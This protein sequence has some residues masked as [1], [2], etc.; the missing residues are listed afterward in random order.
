MKVLIFNPYSLDNNSLPVLLDEAAEYLKDPSTEVLFITCT[1][2]MKPCDI[3]YE[4]S[5]VRCAECRLSTWLLLNRFRASSFSHRTLADYVDDNLRKK[6]E[7]LSFSYRTLDEVKGISHNG[8]NIGLG[9]VSSYVSMTRNLEPELSGENRRFIDEMLQSSALLADALTRIVDD[10]HPDK[11]CVFNGRFGGLRPA[12]EL[13]RSRNI[14]TE[15]FECTFA[16]DR[17]LQRKVK[18]T[19]ALPHDIDNSYKIIEDNWNQKT[20]EDQRSMSAASFFERRRRSEPASDKVYT[21]GQRDGLMPDNWNESKRNFVIF[22]SSEDEFFC[23]GESFDKYKLFTNQIDGVRYIIEQSA[24]DTTIHYYLRVHPNLKEIPFRY[25]VGLKDIFGGYRNITVIGADSPVSTYRLI[26][27]CEKVFVFGST[28][29]VE[30][31]YWGKPVVLMGGAFYLHLD[32]AY[33]ARSLPELN[34]LIVGRLEPKPKLGALKYALF[35]FGERGE[36]PKHCDFDFYTLLLGNKRLQIPRCYAFKG[37][38]FPYIALLGFFRTLNL[39]SHIR[40]KRF[41]VPKMMVEIS[42]H[43]PGQNSA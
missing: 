3:N 37:K 22:N 38:L 28:A 25:H 15:V 36:R 16:G 29:G 4:S 12:F 17:S 7:S 39:L 43:A 5:S 9:V 42:G 6:I 41:T 35:I 27:K 14:Q 26:D 19:N 10:Y 21:T 20:D 33:Y 18:F 24:N 40:F 34:E 13:G 23:V 8:L 30:A 32:V 1:G 31:A 11:I 2:D